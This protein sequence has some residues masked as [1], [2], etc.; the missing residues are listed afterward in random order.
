MAELLDLYQ[1]NEV[2]KDVI[3]YLTTALY[4]LQNG[5]M[6]WKKDFMEKSGFSL[7]KAFKGNMGFPLK[8]SDN[9]RPSKDVLDTLS[10][11]FEKAFKFK[12]EE[13]VDDFCTM[14]G[15]DKEYVTETIKENGR[16]QKNNK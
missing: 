4:N 2:N 1:Q 6:Y 16:K 5:V 12:V 14:F 9:P 15:L 7:S 8:E 11:C 3:Q 13:S 10:D